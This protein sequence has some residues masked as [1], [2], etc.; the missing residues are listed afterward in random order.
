VSDLGENLALELD[1]EGEEQRSKRK[2]IVKDS[3]TSP[4]A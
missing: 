4:P 3:G 2:K 1:R